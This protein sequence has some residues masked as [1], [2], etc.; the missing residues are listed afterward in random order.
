MFT[1]TH[2][3]LDHDPSYGSGSVPSK[4]SGVFSVVRI[5]EVPAQR[6]SHRINRA[7]LWL[8]DHVASVQI[9]PVKPSYSIDKYI[10]YNHLSIY[11]KVFLPSFGDDVEPPTFEE[12]CKDS[13]WVEAIQTKIFALKDYV[14]P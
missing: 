8:Q 2:V 12:A 9:S 6:K 7:L 5:F 14:S 13:R 1:S 4:E 3:P 11:Y 10:G